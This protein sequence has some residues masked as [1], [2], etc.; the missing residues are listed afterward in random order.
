MK[1]PMS[2]L[3][4]KWCGH[5]YY[6]EMVQLST[7]IMAGGIIYGLYHFGAEML[8]WF[9]VNNG[10][11]WLLAL[12]TGIV[13]AQVVRLYFRLLVLKYN[14]DER[15]GATAGGTKQTPGVMIS[16][17][18]VL[19]FGF[20]ACQNPV[21]QQD[22]A[23]DTPAD[24]H[25]AHGASRTSMQA[26][27]YADSVNDGLIVTDTLK[28]SP[29]RAAM[30]TIA[31]NHV[32][33]DYGSPGVKGRMIWGGLV[34]Y[35]QVWAAGSHKATNIGFNKALQINGQLV[36]P[37]SYGFFIIPGQ[38]EWTL[39]INKRYEQHLADEYNQDEDIIRVK[40]VPTAVELT[41]RLT[42]RV[43]S[44]GTDSG[45]IEFLWEKKKV[46]LPFKVKA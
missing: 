10:I 8:E 36:E 46:V 9:A 42:Y 34:A 33:I 21:Q 37:G 16:A 7:L 23:K 3:W 24:E 41:Q 19:L 44:T 27:G 13:L 26:F 40:V 45:N 32:H 38:Q 12:V 15:P 28:G 6:T 17:L 31:G 30:A 4:K 14:P 29:R 5:Y 1:N 11:L 20:M 39:I 2:F 22:A 25:A 35:D 18:L 43:I